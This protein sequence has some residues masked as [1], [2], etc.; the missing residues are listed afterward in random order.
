MRG[1]C[2]PSTKSGHL[3]TSL[4]GLYYLKCH[5]GNIRKGLSTLFK[6]VHGALQC[7]YQAHH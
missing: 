4:P 3:A 6:E 7:S 5:T 2:M 1:K